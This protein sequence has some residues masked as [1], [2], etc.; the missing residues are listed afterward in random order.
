MVILSS[1]KLKWKISRAKC[2]LRDS[3]ALSCLSCLGRMCLPSPGF[4][5]TG[6]DRPF[7]RLRGQ[8]SQRQDWSCALFLNSS[9]HNFCANAAKS[10]W[11]KN[12]LILM[13]EL[14]SC[15]LGMGWT[16]PNYFYLFLYIFYS[17]CPLVL[18]GSWCQF[19][20][21]APKLY[22]SPELGVLFHPVLE[23]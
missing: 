3:V 13:A 12:P 22:G 20:F 9:L 11:R 10:W 19:S 8:Q 23:I 18:G 1:K 7:K 17:Y 2:Q 6:M 14:L 16:L 4:S 21:P 15:P 5:W